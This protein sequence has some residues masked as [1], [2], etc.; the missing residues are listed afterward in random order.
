MSLRH[1][2]GRLEAQASKKAVTAGVDRLLSFCTEEELDEM[3]RL[4]HKLKAMAKETGISEMALLSEN[5]EGMEIDRRMGELWGRA[6]GRMRAAD[7]STA[8]NHQD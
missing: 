4:A 8:E 1:R 7:E 3:T 5:V 2:I 6:R